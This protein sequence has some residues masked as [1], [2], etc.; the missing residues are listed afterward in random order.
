LDKGLGDFQTPPEL[1]REILERPELRATEWARV[2]EPTCGEGTFIE[3][4]AQEIGPREIVGI[5][6]Q[7][8]HVEEARRRTKRLRST[9]VRVLERD[10][11]AMNLGEDI[12]WKGGGPLLVI[13][14]PPWVTNAALGTLGSDNR[15][16][17]SNIKRLPGLAAMTGDSNFDIAEYIFLKLLVELR[18]QSPT[19]ALLCKSIVARNVL[20]YA[21]DIHLPVEGSSL[22]RI[23]SRRWFN[24]SADA[25]LFI[26][27]LRPG[28]Q[29]FESKVYASLNATEADSTMGVVGGELVS[30]VAGFIAAR[31]FHGLS[32]IEWRQGVKHD[33]ASVMELEISASGHLRAKGGDE[34]VVDSEYVYP[35]LKSTD[36]FHG[37]TAETGRRVIVTQRTLGEDTGPLAQRAPDLWRY[38]NKHRDVFDARKSSI[39]RERPPFSMFGVGDYAFAPY[40]VAIS[41]LHKIPRF[42]LIGPIQGRPAVLDDTCYLLPFESATEAAIVAGLL[43]SEQSLTLLDAMT[44]WDSKRPITKRVLRRVDL[45]ALIEGLPPESWIGRT[46]EMLMG[47]NAMPGHP[48]PAGLVQWRAAARA[49]SSGWNRGGVAREAHASDRSRVAYPSA[50]HDAPE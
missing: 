25:C 29:T 16:E 5:D 30:N 31:A 9:D 4:V 49:A 17:R 27:T 37:R 22:F 14:N 18:S 44:F 32:P 26:V 50:V 7:R 33:A 34:A 47:L 35:L 1:V 48:P 10:I 24:A 12:S 8:R 40:K 45:T 15:P 21:A 2:L 38:L 46:E 39:Y 20:K 42:R 23:D 6:I 43:T 41:G 13:G 36:L 19:F 28:R 3:G 11:F